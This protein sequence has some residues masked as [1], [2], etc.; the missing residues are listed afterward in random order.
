MAETKEISRDLEAFSHLIRLW[1]GEN[2]IKTMKL[3]VLLAVNAGLIAAVELNGGFVFGNLPLFLGGLVVCL[4]WT[5][6]IGRTTLAQRLWKAK[7][8]GIAAK[9]PNDPRFQITNTEGVHAE[10]P[11]W[12]HLLGGVPSRYYLLGTP[13]GFGLMWLTTSL[14]SLLSA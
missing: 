3:Q 6:S 4:I 12:L 13:V 11:R 9:H 8:A 7:M 5:L 1:A 2:P 10:A 14:Y